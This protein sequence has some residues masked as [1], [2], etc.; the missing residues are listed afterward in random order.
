MREALRGGY[1]PGW[2]RRCARPDAAG[3]GAAVFVKDGDIERL[4]I[5]I[6]PATS[7]LSASQTQEYIRQ[8]YLSR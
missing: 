2:S 3:A 6:G 5:R 8:R 7:E 1:P 4:Y